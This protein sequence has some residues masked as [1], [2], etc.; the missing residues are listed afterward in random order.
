MSKLC[1][2][3]LRIFLVG[4]KIGNR[5]GFKNIKIIIKKFEEMM[6]LMK[7]KLGRNYFIFE[8]VNGRR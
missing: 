2:G 4:L 5:L 7:R 1:Y 6:F 3:F 8:E